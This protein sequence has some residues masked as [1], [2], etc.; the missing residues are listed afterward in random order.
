MFRTATVEAKNVETSIERTTITGAEGLYRFESLLPGTYDV[1][2]RAQGF[3][4]AVN[5]AVKLE[6]G[7]QRDVNFA[8]N[9]G[10]QAEQVTVTSE[11]PLVETTKTDVS[12]VVSDKEVATLPT[13]T[14][15]N[16]IGGVANDYQGLAVTAPGVK[17]DFTGV[18]SDLIGPGVP[19]DRGIQVNVDGGNISDQVVSTRDAL[20]ASVEEGK[21]ES[22]H[23]CHEGTPKSPVLRSFPVNPIKKP[24]RLSAFSALSGEVRTRRA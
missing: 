21:R 1:T 10:G 18:S 15:F 13:T 23:G 22:H 9:I 6:V 14:S 11:A 20:G 19:N 17:Y 3:A 4:T 16:G 24:S 7:D 8:L 5:K 12:T 2:A